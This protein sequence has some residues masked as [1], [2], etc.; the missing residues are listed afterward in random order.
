MKI[1]LKT[2]NL[3]LTKFHSRLFD[4][5]D[6]DGILIPLNI[7]LDEC[8]LSDMV[9]E[10]DEDFHGIKKNVSLAWM[11]SKHPY[12]GRWIGC[13]LIPLRHNITT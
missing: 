11:Y 9:Y 8:V 13:I 12:Q 10:L 2:K 6:Q 4:K 1:V 7:L 3:T 5:E